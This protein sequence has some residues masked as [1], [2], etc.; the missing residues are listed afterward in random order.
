M[1]FHSPY[2][3]DYNP[4]AELQ[5]WEEIQR[6]EDASFASASRRS[7]FAESHCTIINCL[8]A[9]FTCVPHPSFLNIIY[10][11]NPA[12]PSGQP[13][14]RG[15][16]RGVQP[17]IRWTASGIKQACAIS[18][19]YCSIRCSERICD[20]VIA[21]QQ[22]LVTGNTHVFDRPRTSASVSSSLLTELHTT[23]NCLKVHLQFIVRVFV[24][25][26][27]FFCRRTLAFLKRLEILATTT[28]AAWRK[29]CST[30]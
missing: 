25:E 29:F 2:Q 1:I 13:L 4:L 10:L 7:F 18:R 8:I 15:S 9:S 26:A 3:I 14:L 17:P 20:F 11:C 16:R 6:K 19:A 28:S 23:L 24:F 30:R 27:S 12:H 22:R 21:V 5:K